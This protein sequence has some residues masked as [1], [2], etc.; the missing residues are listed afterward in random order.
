MR[1]DPRSR[2]CGIGVV[3][4]RT[5]FRWFTPLGEPGGAA[6]RRAGCVTFAVLRDWGCGL[7]DFVPMVHSVGRAW[8][9][10]DTAGPAPP[11]GLAPSPPRHHG[12]PR[13]N[14][15]SYF[16]PE[17]P[18]G[19]TTPAP[20]NGL[21]P[22]PPRHHGQPRPNQ[23]SY[24][25]PEKPPGKPTST[26]APSAPASLPRSRSPPP[27]PAAQPSRSP[28]HSRSR[29]RQPHHR[30]RRRCRDRG[31]RRRP[32]RPSPAAARPRSH[33]SDCARIMR[34]TARH[35]RV[36]AARSSLYSCGIRQ[37][38]A[39]I[40]LTAHASCVRQHDTDVCV[41]HGRVCTRAASD[42]GTAITHLTAVRHPCHRSRRSVRC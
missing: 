3:A 14:Q 42:T 35:R 15:P 12:Q 2:C 31:R 10:G 29:H 30:H 25:H 34:A 39:V 13:P 38:V 37:R 6:T 11:N 9:C 17:K 27:P 18:P 22:S 19:T 4:C 16:H 7:P 5:S 8:R 21:A 20:P 40:D 41:L 36:C 26:T 33:R 24:F 32:P 28:A 1:N 23:P